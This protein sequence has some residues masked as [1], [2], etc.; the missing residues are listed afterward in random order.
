MADENRWIST[1][2]TIW[3]PGGGNWSLGHKPLAGEDV[4]VGP[5][6]ADI[7]SG[8]DEDNAAVA[9]NSFHRHKLY[10][11]NI[12]TSSDPLVLAT[13]ATTDPVNSL[14]PKGKVIVQGP[15]AFYYTNGTGASGT[16]TTDTVYIDTDEQSTAIEVDGEIS[17]LNLLKG[18]VTA[19]SNFDPGTIIVAYR[20]NPAT[21]VHLTLQG[22]AAIGAILQ[23]GG[24][25]INTGSANVIMLDVANGTFDHGASA[26]ATSAITQ[27]GGTI[28]HRAAT[29]VGLAKIVGG[30][31]DM[32][33]DPREKT[34]SLLF[35]FPGATFLPNAH[36]TI[37]QGGTV[38]PF[39]PIKPGTF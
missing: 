27:S 10:T 8:F 38:F 24:K 15:G 34:I 39:T 28:I 23:Q 35:V 17:H 3:G 33:Q 32:S 2:T 12:G 26:G 16:Q 25:V 11:G 13:L 29:S 7:L 4:V 9:V 19:L 1:D 36:I 21:D 5:D 20:T 37:S 6:T 22:S 18:R 14:D 31:L 30:T